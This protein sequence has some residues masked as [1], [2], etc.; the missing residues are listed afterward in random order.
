MLR[1]E[2]YRCKRCKEVVKCDVGKSSDH[3]S[4]PHPDSVS[5]TVKQ[6]EGERADVKTVYT[7]ICET[8]STTHKSCARILLLNI[9]PENKKWLSRRVYCLLDDQSNRS[10]ATSN[11]F[12]TFGNNSQDIVYKLGSCAGQVLIAGRIATGYV[13]ESLDSSGCFKLPELVECNNIPKIDPDLFFFYTDSQ[14]VLGYI[15]NE[16]RRFYAF[17]GNRVSHIRLSSKPTKWKYVQSDMNPADI[18]T[19]SVDAKDLQDCACLK[20]PKFLKS[21][22]RDSGLRPF[23]MVDPDSDKEVRPE[24]RCYKTEE[25]DAYTPRLGSH[26]FESFSDWKV[27]VK[28]TALLKYVAR[29]HGEHRESD[30]PDS[31]KDPDF[32][33]ETERFLLQTVQGEVYKT[34]IE[35]IRG[36]G[37]PSRNSSLLTLAPVLDQH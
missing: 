13:V 11:L 6:H 29:L 14:V 5:H 1:T 4:A 26:R 3:P 33:R 21:D 8:P 36:D 12:D 32:H 24:V 25:V 28:S 34:E 30:L 20:G 23:P 37:S 15:T 19:R 16:T 31:P 35:A 22:S 18:P 27:L 2:K 10:L 9:Y 17:V 7:E